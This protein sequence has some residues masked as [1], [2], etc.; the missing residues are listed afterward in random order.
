M[1]KNIIKMICDSRLELIPLLG[2]ALRGI[3][4][5]SGMDEELLYFLELCLDEAMSNI[6]IHSYH[7][8]AGHDI[9]V[10]IILEVDQVTI[11]IRDSGIKNTVPYPSELTY[12]P[13][14]LNSMPESGFGCFLINQL[15]DKVIYKRRSGKNELTLHKNFIR[16]AVGAK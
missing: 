1:K 3:C 2:K 14:D 6:I 16:K 10:E 7:R 5:Y 12:D 13:S 8:E 9:E 15:M 4:S 11:K